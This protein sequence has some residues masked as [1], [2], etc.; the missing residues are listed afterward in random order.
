L[1]TRRS[2][3]AVLMC[4]LVLIASACAGGGSTDDATGGEGGTPT[5]RLAI[6]SALSQSFIPTIVQGLD[7]DQDEGFELETQVLETSAEVGEGLASGDVTLASIAD[8]T[9][10]TLLSR[11]VP[12]TV[13]SSIVNS[14]RHIQLIAREDLGV[15]S[16][17][18]LEGLSIGLPFGSGASVLI[19]ALIDRYRLDASQIEQIDLAPDAIPAAYEKGDID[20][21]IDWAPFTYSAMDAVP[22]V[23]LHDGYESYFPDQEG[24]DHVS[25]V[26]LFLVAQNAFL[27]DSE[28]RELGQA[29]VRAS[30]SAMDALE[31]PKLRDKALAAVSEATDLEGSVVNEVADDQFIFQQEIDESVMESFYISGDLLAKTDA[32]EEPPPHDISEW[33]ELGW[34]DPDFVEEAGI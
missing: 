23:K 11:G 27:E 7:L 15:N 21:L 26:V 31:D 9:A 14:T 8:S 29:Y 12:V 20:A 17:Q 28:S 33:A 2:H 5:L 24:T 32:I 1:R 18:D 6:T 3:I 25:T 34:L 16:P 10:L 22:S 19:A 30:Q 13:V 4:T